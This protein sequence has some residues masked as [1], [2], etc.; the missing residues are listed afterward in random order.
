MIT[1][2][3]LGKM[4]NL[5][6][7]LFQIATV[8]GLAKKHNCE[9]V[10]PKWQYSPYFVNPPRE[11]DIDT[12]FT[13][14]E[15]VFHYTPWDDCEGLFQSMNVDIKGWLQS[16]KYFE[17]VDWEF[18][19]WLLDTVRRQYD[20]SKPTIAISVRRGDYVD[21]PHYELLPARYYVHS[22]ITHFP[23]YENYNII[24]FSD[25]QQYCKIHFPTAQI[26]TGS[27]IEQLALMS[28]C[29]HFI[30]ANSTFSWWGA[31]LGQKP[32][33]KVIRPNY[34]FAG[35]L[36][37][38]SSDRD[39]WP[40][41]W[42]VFDHKKQKIDLSDV[43]FTIPYF[44]DHYDREQNLELTLRL[45]REDFNT[46]ITIVENRSTTCP[47]AVHYDLEHFHRTRILN[48]M[49]RMAQTPFIANWDT[50]VNIPPLQLYE[51]VKALR[52]GADMIY[53]YDGRFARVPRRYYSKVFDK[54][55][56]GMCNGRFSGTHDSE[57]IS[58]GGAVLFNRESFFRGGGENENFISYGKED[59]ERYHRFTTLGFDVRRIEGTLFHIDHWIGFNSSRKNPFYET[60]SLEWEKVKDMT[61]E[62][63]EE[64]VSSWV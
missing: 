9:A 37:L 32:H 33:S 12:H 24:C 34:L 20:L 61:R 3:N 18:Q 48:D 6:N 58:V 17:S 49:A 8:Q 28:L 45:L 25:D 43:T 39:F 7:Q 10:F 29:D 4:G 30:V 23:D 16:P 1:F 64:Y 62:E 57:K 2:K 51:A 11:E 27:P 13:V 26:C 60:G 47:E 55:D 15:K 52:E 53:P 22:L 41:D 59:Q 14:V 40:E 63:L 54:R 21:N 36:M 56:I 31:F 5:G 46:N 42:I 19:P 35:E 38:H 44:R 50:D